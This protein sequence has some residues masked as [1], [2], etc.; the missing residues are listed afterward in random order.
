MLRIRIFPPVASESIAPAATAKIFIM[1]AML[2]N[3]VLDP[4]LNHTSATMIGQTGQSLVV[5][6]LNWI[7]AGEDL[8]GGCNLLP[9]HFC[10]SIPTLEPHVVSSA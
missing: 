4:R 2:N 6:T 7:S 8:L 1:S 3:D 9:T 5:S 10:R